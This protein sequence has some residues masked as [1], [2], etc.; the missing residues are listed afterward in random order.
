MKKT[1]MVAFCLTVLFAASALTAVVEGLSSTY[2]FNNYQ[3]TVTPTLDG[4]W[5]SPGEWTD[6]GIPPFQPTAFNWREKWTYPGDINE[7]VLIEV[8]SNTNDTGDVITYCLDTGANGGATPQTDDVKIE[9]TGNT[10]S[11]VKVYKGTGS[12]WTQ[13]SVPSADLVVKIGSGTS[14]LSSTEHI[15]IEMM[16]NRSN[17]NFDTSAGSYAPGIRVSSYDASNSAAGTVAWPPS[18]TDT[19][20]A[21]WG[22]ETG[23]MDTIP[24][25]LTL[26]TII[27]LTSVAVVG[28]VFLLKK[29]TI[30]LKPL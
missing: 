17:A 8:F 23:T 20:P 5:T 30:A 18:T 7:Q 3:A 25:S 19:A 29:R 2:I 26:L 27:A 21:G 11:G 16:I 15:I 4:A 10:A 28:S 22:T 12:G 6:V 13:I 14:P 9:I 1:L 24:E